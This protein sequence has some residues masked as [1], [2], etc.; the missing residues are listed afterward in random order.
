MS[1]PTYETQQDSDR[2]RLVVEAMAS[3]WSLNPIK[4]PKFYKQDWALSKMDRTVKAVVEVK[5]RSHPKHT[6]DT[7]ILSLDKWQALAMLSERTS[8]KGLLG[9]RYTDGIFWVVAQHQP[10]WRITIGG[11]TDRNDPDDVEPVIHIPSSSLKPL[12]T[13]GHPTV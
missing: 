5:C 8:I 9:V 2:E 1:R 10:D 12:F 7:L 3:A 11:R 4:L 6:Y 13:N